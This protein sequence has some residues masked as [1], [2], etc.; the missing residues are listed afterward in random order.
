MSRII[1]CIVVTLA[2]IVVPT[3]SELLT[4]TARAGE[5]SPGAS[6]SGSPGAAVAPSPSPAANPDAVTHACDDKML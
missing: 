5:P 2:L 6:P 3:G 4:P 1:G